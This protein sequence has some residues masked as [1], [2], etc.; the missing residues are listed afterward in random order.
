MSSSSSKTSASSQE[1]AKEDVKE[2]AKTST[3]TT[4]I[5]P[6]LS[7]HDYLSLGEVELGLSS[8]N[9][10]GEEIQRLPFF[11]RVLSLT[12]PLSSIGILGD[13][14]K[15]DGDDPPDPV[16]NQV[17]ARLEHVAATYNVAEGVDVVTCHLAPSMS[18]KLSKLSPLQKQ[19]EV[20]NTQA[21]TA[22]AKHPTTS[23]SKRRRSSMIEKPISA[24]NSAEYSE[25]GIQGSSDQGSE[26]DD[27]VDEEEEAPQTLEDFPSKKRKLGTSQR[28]DSL[29][30]NRAAEDSQEATVT[31]TLSEL[32]SLVASSLEPLC[33][34]VDDSQG[35]GS[36][37]QKLSLTID[38]SI[39]SERGT[40]EGVG[41]AMA[42]S[43]LGSTVAAI[44]HHA[45]VLRSRHVA[46]CTVSTEIKFIAS[47]WLFL[48]HGG[49]RLTLLFYLFFCHCRTP[50]AEQPFPRQVNS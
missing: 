46:V 6:Q 27:D 7:L 21:L 38:D 4:S 8:E 47:G 9:P 5:D 12:R 37:G 49:F 10:P 35:G 24:T 15:E 28:R 50:S 34:D 14:E 13:E 26:Q 36:K 31:K 19:N 33:K 40:D 16:V 32:A 22:V 42:G 2:E 41:G 11:L 30:E 3:S 20:W 25:D 43:D 44:M 45:P 18:R 17:V 23:R 1:D 48:F 39:L 29:G